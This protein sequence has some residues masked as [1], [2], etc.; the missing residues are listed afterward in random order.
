MGEVYRARD[1]RLDRTVA[2]KVL[3]AALAGDPA[4]RQRFDREAR[5]ISSLSHPHICPLFDV[6]QQEGVDFLVMEYLEAETLA[7]RLARE[8]LPLGQA[9]AT[10]AAPPTDRSWWPPSPWRATRSAPRSR[11][12]GPKAISRHGGQTACSIC[13]PDGER[14]A[15]AVAAPTQ[16]AKR[17]HVTFIFN[18]FDELRRIA[19]T[20]KK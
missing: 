14:F 19:P 3:S 17:D 4:L 13:T 2:I 7:R 15:L 6:G 1:T 11:G 9:L 16:G 5:A 12:S 10:A 8:A 20:T 18:F